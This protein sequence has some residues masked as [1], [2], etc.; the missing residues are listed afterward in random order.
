[1]PKQVE[2]M[3]GCHGLRG[4]FK[5]GARAGA[6]DRLDKPM[7][8]HDEHNCCAEHGNLDHGCGSK[9][10]CDKGVIRSD[11]TLG[12][13]EIGRYTSATF[14]TKED[15]DAEVDALV[16]G[17]TAIGQKV[18]D[19]VPL[20]A[21]VIAGKN[22]WSA[23]GEAEF[24]KTVKADH[25]RFLKEH[26]AGEHDHPHPDKATFAAAKRAAKAN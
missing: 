3:D 7:E 10:A 21:Q 24:T 20:Y 9:T 6:L 17:L 11:G 19:K 15:I 26:A 4:S 2:V 23:K 22:I 16:A 12:P 18:T 14:H 25:A 13:C 8:A 5:K 1:M